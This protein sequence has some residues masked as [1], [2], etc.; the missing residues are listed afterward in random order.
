MNIWSDVLALAF[1]C[2]TCSTVRSEL[3]R[4]SSDSEC[5]GVLVCCF[6][7]CVDPE[8]VHC[9][10]NCNVDSDCRPGESCTD[11]FCRVSRSPTRQS[12]TL[13]TN[14]DFAVSTIET[15][16]NYGECAL[17][18]DCSGSRVCNYDGQCVF[19]SNGSSWN[20]RQFVGIIVFVIL[21]TV[22]ACLVQIYRRA[23]KPPVLPHQ[24]CAHQLATRTNATELGS[25]VAAVNMETDAPP[26]Y[27]SLGF[28]GTEGET[29]L[30][31]PPPS[32]DEAVRSSNAGIA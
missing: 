13:S 26:P 7:I 6:R 22:G 2:Y 10:D 5:E 17:D 3:R 24:T 14:T 4:C 18:S 9:T 15:S 31:A 27:Q 11:F 30:E 23:R 29:P 16:A 19:N 28:V 21:A 25:T 12:F 32:Y 1:V 8:Y 20:G